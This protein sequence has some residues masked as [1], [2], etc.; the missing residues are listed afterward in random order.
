MPRTRRRN[1]LPQR[2]P[3]AAPPPGRRKQT[4]DRVIRTLRSHPRRAA[5]AGLLILAVI[6][7]IVYLAWP[8][9]YHGYQPAVRTRAYTNS[10]ACL[11][12]DATGITGTAAPVWAGM[13]AASRTNHEQVSYLTMQGADTAANADTYINTLAL[14]GCDTILAAGTL[15]DQ[16]ITD[17][18][19]A[20][21]K[22][23][24]ITIATPAANT[25]PTPTTD[26]AN[27]TSIT[28][29][30]ANATTTAVQTALTHADPIGTSTITPTTS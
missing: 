19:G 7:G 6:A 23:H 29:T 11:L 2:T 26:P 20:Y 25:N 28:E 18:A 5:G 14:R 16:G 8:T 21:P 9:P 12:T 10:T 4:T 15:P 13:Q 17:R 27:V 1:N 3:A 30:T 22:L 24:F